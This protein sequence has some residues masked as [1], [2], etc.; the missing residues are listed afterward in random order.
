MSTL[1]RRVSFTAHHFGR[2]DML[3]R[4]RLSLSL[5]CIAAWGVVLSLAQVPVGSLSG[6]VHDQTGG[7]M[8]G[9]TVTVTNKDTGRARQVVTAVDGSFRVSPLLPGGYTV[10]A[11]ASGFRTL[12]ENA[13]VQVGQTT[14][15]ELAMQVGAA[16]EVVSVQ[17]EA[18]QI[19][20]DSHTI[21]G[22]ITRQEIENLPLNGRSFLNLAMLEPG[23][24]VSPN[25]VG[26]YNRSFD[27]SILGADSSNGS[28]RITVD[29]ARSVEKHE[30][31]ES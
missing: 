20:Y 31:Y 29:G 7:V 21:G 18:A 15:I 17:G 25:P 5:L 1:T 6:T 2:G 22:V 13:T 3:N 19:D 26:Q 8:Q 12:L 10:K 24:T 11:E 23:V 27:V 4:M 16:A 30:G 14:T 9:A 28:V